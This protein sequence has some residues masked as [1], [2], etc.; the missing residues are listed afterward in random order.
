MF[1]HRLLVFAV[2][3]IGCGAPPSPHQFT[4]LWTFNGRSCTA[5]G[6]SQISFVRDGVSQSVPCR[7]AARDGLVL[8]YDEPTTLR[9]LVAVDEEGVIF[10]GPTSELRLQLYPDAPELAVDFFNEAW[11]YRV[12]VESTRACEQRTVSIDQG[13]RFS[14]PCTGP[15]GVVLGA[16]RHDFFFGVEAGCCTAAETPVIRTNGQPQTIDDQYSRFVLEPLNRAF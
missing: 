10:N 13:S 2:L 15:F 8:S 6:I 4:L 12:T 1:N 11:L 7:A 16:G 5:A 3:V 9:D 14:V